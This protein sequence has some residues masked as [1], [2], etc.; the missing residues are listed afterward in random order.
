MTEYIVQDTSLTAVA[1]KIREKTGD[2]APLEFPDDFITAIDNLSPAL[3]PPATPSDSVLFYSRTPISLYI[4]NKLWNGSLYYS[5]DHNSWQELQNATIYE[6]EFNGSW[7]TLYVRGESNTVLSNGS[8]GARWYISGKG[9]KCVGNLN[10]LLDYTQTITS[11]ASKAMAHIFNKCASVDFDVSLPA[12]QLGTNAYQSMFQD[13]TSMT[14]APDL[15]ATILGGS[16]YRDM[17]YGCTALTDIP[18]ILPALTVDS[19]CYDRMFG[20][21][22]SLKK[23]PKLPATILGNYCYSSMFQDCYSLE[24]IPELPATSLKN[25]CYSSMFRGCSK[26]KMSSTQIDEYQT[27]YRIPSVGIGTDATSSMVDMF[28]LT[29]GT[30]TGTPMINVAFYTSNTVIPA[31]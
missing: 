4:A 14:K 13:C 20:Y 18:D 3:T 10:N 1:N 30:F 9:I 28:S 6:A 24:Q 17:F 7:Y 31:T 22:Y 23:C 2:V 16:C 12:L 15:P 21:C 25:Y 8:N 19:D 5:V 11:I 26:I 27:A 29:G